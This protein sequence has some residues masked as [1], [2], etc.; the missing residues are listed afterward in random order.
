[1]YSE[2]EYDSLSPYRAIPAL[3]TYKVISRNFI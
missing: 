2:Q 1:M 3:D